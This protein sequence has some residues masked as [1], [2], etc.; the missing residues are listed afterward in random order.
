M[1]EST[2]NPDIDYKATNDCSYASPYRALRNDAT[3]RVSKKLAREIILHNYTVDRLD[4]VH[5]LQLKHI[6]LG[7]YEVKL[8]HDCASI[9]GKDVGRNL[10]VASFY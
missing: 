4:K 10:I 6:G 2:F 9:N 5:N 8:I 7:V 3:I 1:N